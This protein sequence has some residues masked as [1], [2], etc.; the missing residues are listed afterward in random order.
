MSPIF[1]SVGAE[2]PWKSRPAGQVRIGLAAEAAL[3]KAAGR[4]VAIDGFEMG[5]LR[6]PYRGWKIAA[7]ILF[8]PIWIPVFFMVSVL[9]VIP[10]WIYFPYR[11]WREWEDAK[12]VGVNPGMMILG[13]VLVFGFGI[14]G[15]IVL[16]LVL[17]GKVI[18]LGHI[19]VVAR[20]GDNVALL[21]QETPLFNFAQFRKIDYF[22]SEAL[23]RDPASTGRKVVLSLA[24]ADGTKVIVV[25]RISTWATGSPQ[26][27]EQNLQTLLRPRTAFDPNEL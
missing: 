14:I 2:A 16:T 13:V 9:M 25:R 4:P 7:L 5:A 23:V 6:K 18:H 3:G 27:N 17:L 10:S 8:S 20:T 11:T 19:V 15:G 1:R 22:S 21:Y 26:V 12:S 24:G